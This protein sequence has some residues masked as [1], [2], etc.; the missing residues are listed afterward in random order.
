MEN[1]PIRTYKIGALKLN[2]WR[3]KG[4]EGEYKTFTFERIYKKD[5]EWQSTQ[6]LRIN[7]LLKLQLLLNKAYENEVLESKENIE[8]EEVDVEK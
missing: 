1:K 6:S 2:V 4:K 3:N 7:D 5:E 8:I